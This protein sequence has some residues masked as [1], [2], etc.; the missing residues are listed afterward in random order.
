MTKLPARHPAVD[1]GH[2]LLMGETSDGLGIKVRRSDVGE[3]IRPRLRSRARRSRISFT[4]S[5]QSPSKNTSNF[6]ESPL[7]FKKP[8][9][10]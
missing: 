1:F 10:I 6:I 3:Q 2:K 8:Y 4:H 7:L 9:Q 5:G